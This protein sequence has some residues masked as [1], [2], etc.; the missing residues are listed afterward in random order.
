MSTDLGVRASGT[1]LLTTEQAAEFLG[2]TPRFL[3]VRRMRGGGP[4]YVN[5]SKRA[6]RYSLTDLQ[7]WIAART[8]GST[9]EVSIHR[10]K[11]EQ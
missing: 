9:S 4:R 11:H 3:E 2:I 10:E 8:V 6:V 5:I 1:G 7:A